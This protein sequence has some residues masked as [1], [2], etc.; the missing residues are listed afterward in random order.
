MGLDEK[1]EDLEKIRESLVKVLNI[2]SVIIITE[3]FLESLVIL[4]AVL[5]IPVEYL[6][7]LS[8]NI[9]APYEKPALN[10]EQ[11]R[12]FEKFNRIDIMMYELAN[13]K[14]D[15]GSPKNP[16]FYKNNFFCLLFRKP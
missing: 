11:T 10:E 14:L 15:Q 6:Y 2:F 9:S 8:H 5:H 7:A 12:I 4:A 3:R 16:R 1:M 13:Q